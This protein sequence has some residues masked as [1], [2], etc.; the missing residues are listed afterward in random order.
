M[1]DEKTLIG[2]HWVTL[3]HT[4]FTMYMQNVIFKT[5]FNNLGNKTTAT[6]LNDPPP[7]TRIIWQCRHKYS[8]NDKHT[9]IKTLT[10]KKI[11]RLEV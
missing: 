9:G 7:P 6:I 2:G 3:T 10:M 4:Q 11:F 5:L 8:W 1:T